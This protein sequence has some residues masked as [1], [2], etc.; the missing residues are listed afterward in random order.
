VSVKEEPLLP[1]P[2]TRSFFKHPWLCG[3][4][5][6]AVARCEARGVGGERRSRPAMARAKVD[7]RINEGMALR[8]AEEAGE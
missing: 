4:V 3:P 1:S 5:V 2:R 6:L 8:K 7:G